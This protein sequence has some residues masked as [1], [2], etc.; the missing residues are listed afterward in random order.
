MISLSLWNLNELDFQSSTGILRLS[1]K[2]LGGRPFYSYSPLTKSFLLGTQP[3]A[4]QP[5]LLPVCA[6]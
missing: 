5:G 3:S 1:T 6:L 4:S 2:Q